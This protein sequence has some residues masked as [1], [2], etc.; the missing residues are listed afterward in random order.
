MAIMIR[1]S[2]MYFVVY[3]GSSS[4]SAEALSSYTLTRL[5][6]RLAFLYMACLLVWQ[7]RPVSPIQHKSK[8]KLT[9]SL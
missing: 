2:V 9:L 1:D 3:V 5:L 4:E 6:Y 7:L 8:V